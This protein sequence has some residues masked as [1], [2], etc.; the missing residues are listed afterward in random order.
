MNII[1][2]RGLKKDYPLGKTTVHA[3]RGVDLDIAKGDL[4]SIV[5]PSGSGK[6]T[7]LNV[8]GCID[9]PTEG[10]VK[11]ADQEVSTLKDKQITDL[12]L[13]RIGFIFQT[14]N[15]IP[16]L[17][18]LENVEFPLLLAGKISKAKA[19]KAAADL[20]KAVGL[21]EYL[22]HRPAEL[23][24]GQRQRV[25]IARALVTEPDI[26][27]ADEP[28]ANL[29]SK[30]GASI[31]DL[32]KEMNERLHTT[33]IFSTHDANVMQYAKSVVKIQDGLIAKD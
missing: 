18:A 3:L 9:H 17:T 13:H 24:G 14:F 15:L 33:F 22:T 6:T 16:V 21:S 5:G 20:L 12:R 32:M 2:I 1:E 30:T 29:D 10:S 7:L 27:L 23:S 25:A 31:L 19:R 11:V 8:I 4:L 28:T 26:V